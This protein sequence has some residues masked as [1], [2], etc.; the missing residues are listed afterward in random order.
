MNSSFDQ[1]VILKR[2]P[3]WSRALIWGI[4]G[5]T[6][7]TILWA[8]IARMEEA[9]SAAGKLEPQVAV[10]EVQVPL[11]GVVKEVHIKEGQR[12]KQGDLLLTMDQ[13]AAEAQQASLKK[14]RDALIAENR[15][16]RGETGGV[17]AG[18]PSPEV[19]A[20]TKNRKALQDENNG[21]RAQLAGSTQGTNLTP[22]GRLRVQASLSESESR[23]QT[24]QLD[25]E[26]LER[27]LAETQVKLEN[28][29]STLS[30][31][32]EIYGKV[33]P[34]ARTG[35]VAQ[36]QALQQQQEVI[37]QQSQ[38][39][40]LTEE[41]Q[42]LRLAIAQSRQKLQNT[43]AFST[44]DVFAKIA[45]NEKRIAEIDSQL[46]KVIVENDKKIAE[47]DS[48]MSQ[49]KVT[50]GYQ[51]VRS[52]VDGIVFDL[53]PK[54]AGF[55]ATSTEPVL[56][57]VPDDALVAEVFITNKDIGFIKPDMTVDVR[58]DSFPFSEFGDIK[59]T[60][61][62]IGS[63]ALPPTEIRPFYSF[64]AKIRLDRQAL[65]IKG[66]EV[67]LQSGM[68]VNVNIKVRDRRVI[69]IF[70]DIFT[71]KVDELKSVR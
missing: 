30:V 53:K 49:T 36:L 37:N 55:V 41:A 63:D 69:D 7:F 34:L 51:E 57:V 20:L 56:K 33:E 68:G 25:G 45:D 24:A 28:A 17:V 16:Y 38:V 64:P 21:Y 43:V 9:V 15:F 65:S 11:N 26:Q 27:Q 29:K 44:Q 1:P 71:Q 3:I 62:S 19:A 2:S 22:E 8:C 59:G 40:Q 67:V 18:N 47:T 10:K 48:Q 60:L 4:V 5:V 12:V 52:P 23:R 50:L 39:S 61:V 14:N 31:S 6:S 70:T 58:V 54:S 42:R 13:R 32:Q 46:N 35:A 66:R